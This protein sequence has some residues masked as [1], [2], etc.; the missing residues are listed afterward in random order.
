MS[1]DQP[2]DERVVHRLWLAGALPRERYAA[3]LAL[4]RDDGFWRRWGERALLALAAGHLL[5]AVLF[6]FAFNWQ[7]LPPMAKLGVLQAGVAA[8]ALASRLPML[9]DILRESLLIAATVLVGV[10]LAVFGQIYQTGADA[11]QLF[12]GW[13]ALTLPWVLAGRSP[14]HWIVWM[15]VAQVAVWTFLDDIK[16][17]QTGAGLPY[18]FALVALPALLLLIGREVM[19]RRLDWLSPGWARLVPLAAVA[20][21]LFTGAEVAVIE[22]EA[23]GAVGLFVAGVAAAAWAFGQWRRDFAALALIVLLSCSLLATM[24]VRLIDFHDETSAFFLAALEISLIFG[25]GSWLLRR[26]HRAWN[27]GCHD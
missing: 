4:A 23:G 1:P 20:G 14:G 17:F 27:G 24:A 10:L 9:P 19:C 8:A 11:W 15:V 2:L 13:A 7:D 5:A 12:A 16:T 18:A 22:S 25:A 26:I 3:A 21:L 6:F